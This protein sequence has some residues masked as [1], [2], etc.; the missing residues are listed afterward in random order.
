MQKIKAHCVWLLLEPLS[1]RGQKSRPTIF[2]A[3]AA[4]LSTTPDCSISDTARTTADK[5]A[6]PMLT[7]HALSSSPPTIHRGQA[8]RSLLS[9]RA[10]HPLEPESGAAYSC[11]LRAYDVRTE[12]GRARRVPVD[13]DL[14]RRCT[15]PSSDAT[16]YD[17]LLQRSSLRRHRARRPRLRGRP[18]CQLL[19][20][21]R[22]RPS[23]G[24]NLCD[25]PHCGVGP[26]TRPNR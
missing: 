15:S 9:I 3:R 26:M 21:G 6:N 12:T 22:R 11:Y 10:R 13:S 16:S 4:A 1:R 25:P 5:T 20:L 24:C 19:L 18:R 14:P 23:H 2:A 17:F 7:L 8:L